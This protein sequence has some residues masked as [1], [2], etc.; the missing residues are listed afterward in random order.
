MEMEQG[1]IKKE[2]V[3]DAPASIVFKALTDEKDLVR[4]MPNEAKI[5]ARIGGEYEFKYHWAERNMDSVV[6]GKIV[7]LVPNQKISYTWESVMKFGVETRRSSNSVVTW[8]L[9]ELPDGKTR[10]MLLQTGVSKELSQDSE[11][12]WTHF[13]NQLARYSESK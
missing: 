9:E 3:V 13:V 1:E 5:D 2:I 12:G 7:E 11:R 4:W 10:V 6:R 8:T